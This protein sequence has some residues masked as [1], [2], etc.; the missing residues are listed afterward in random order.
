LDSLRDLGINLLAA[1][2]GF[3][4]AR[5]IAKARYLWTT[6]SVR[7]FWKVFGTSD[8]IDVVIPIFNEKEMVAYEP[9]GLLGTGD[10]RGLLDLQRTLIRISRPYRIIEADRLFGPTSS[11]GQV[12]IGSPDSNKWTKSAFEQLSPQVRFGTGDDWSVV[13]DLVTSKEYKA[14][15]DEG[16]RGLA[17]DVGIIISAQTPLSSRGHILVLAGAFGFGTQAAA[18]LVTDSVLKL[19]ESGLNLDKPFEV[20]FSVPVVNGDVLEPRIEVARNMA[21]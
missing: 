7:Q 3:V 16:N 4:I 9:S 6:R 10:L 17:K 1:L 21:A 11:P 19:R 20:V 8:S 18:R 13:H 14:G 2:I 12:L 15:R 5:L